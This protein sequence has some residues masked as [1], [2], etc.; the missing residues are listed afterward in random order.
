MLWPYSKAR[1]GVVGARRVRDQMEDDGEKVQIVEADEVVETPSDEA[2]SEQALADL[3]PVVVSS[4]DEEELESEVEIAPAKQRGLVRYDPLESYLAEIRNLPQLSREEEHRLALRYHETKDP[5]AAYR[6]VVANLKLVVMIAREYQRSAQNVLDLVQ[7]GNIGLLEAVKQY[8][9]FRGIRFPSYAVYWIRAYM[10]RYLINNLRLVKIGTTQAQRKLFF[11]LQKEKDR[12]E[13]EGFAPEARLL[14]DRL[15][16]KE[17]EV[18]EMEQR[19]ALPDLSVDAPIRVGSGED[20]GDLHGVLSSG[21][22]NTEEQVADQEFQ[23]RMRAAVERFKGGLDEKE[24]R[25]IELRLLNEEPATLQEIADE[26]KL[27]RERI[28]QIENRLKEKLRDYL[29]GELQLGDDGEVTV[30]ES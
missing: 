18:I 24:R 9:P 11:N 13:A 7:E 17:S 26:F 21:A 16:V 1:N 6:L 27:S 14:A 12:L 25:I 23:Q 19:L 8:D 2:F 28:R 4:T 3:A 15:D 29:R 22:L 20:G 10:L 5:Q 30:D